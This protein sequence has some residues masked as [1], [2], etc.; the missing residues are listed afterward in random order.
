M[1]NATR[2]EHMGIP[3]LCNFIY[4][5]SRLDSGQDLFMKVTRGIV[6]YISCTYDH[7]GEF[8]LG[9]MSEQGLPDLTPPAPP[10]R[11]NPSIAIVEI[12]KLDLKDYQNKVSWHRENMGKVF[13]LV[14]NQCTAAV[15]D[16]LEVSGDWS[17]L[18]QGNN[19]V[20]LVQLVK[21]SLFKK[22]TT[23]QYMH[24]ITDA[25]EAL[26][27]FWQGP[28]MSCE[29]Y[30]KKIIGLIEV[31]EHLRGKPRTTCGCIRQ[32][33]SETIGEW[34]DAD[35]DYMPDPGDLAAVKATARSLYI[36]TILTVRSD[37][38]RYGR[39]IANM[40]NDHMKGVL[41]VYLTAQHTAYELLLNWQ[42]GDPPI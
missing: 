39:L 23:R 20:S 35:P 2:K 3:E 32:H 42:S 19:V 27:W 26:H 17:G 15:P 6:E 16:K 21:S 31:Y 4:N 25:E 41:N 8:C 1:T 33:M 36:A 13:P 38:M 30:Q 11:E 14:L 24:S 7:A 37:K 5:V 28:K 12:Y 9:V 40:Q 18:N 29:E 34:M 22:T 10:T